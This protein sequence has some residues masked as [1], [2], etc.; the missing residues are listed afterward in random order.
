MSLWLVRAG[1]FGDQEQIALDE[2]VVTIGWNELPSL[3]NVTSK[4]DLEILYEQ[5][6]NEKVSNQINQIYRFLKEIQP[7][8]LVALPLKSQSSIA[9][10]IIETK[11]QF[12]E[13][14][15]NVKHIRRVTWKKIISRAQIPQDLLHSFGSLL[16]VCKIERNNAEDRIKELINQTVEVQ[17]NIDSDTE[18]FSEIDIEDYS[19][20][21][22]L[23]YIA[24]RFNG[25]NLTRLVAQILSAQDYITTVS[26][27]GPDGGIDIL[28]GK[29]SLGLESPKLCVQVKSGNSPV[30]VKVLR[31][32]IGVMTKIKSEQALLVSWSGFTKPTI[33]EAANDYF[34]VRL[35]D[36]GNIIDAIFKYYDRFDDELKAEIP[37]KRVWSLVSE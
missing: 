11:Y 34:T 31:E 2:N 10:G 26:P 16:T 6:Y 3:E 14:A 20:D 22:I 15:D 29:G 30:D 4:N 33:K 32:L 8:D 28:A 24:K 27:P 12:E 19:K 13:L 35:W 37:L 25:H 1:K 17:K 5:V 9:F 18:D 21:E 23:K 36:S 7:L